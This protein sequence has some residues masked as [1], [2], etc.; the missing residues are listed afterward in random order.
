M[1]V[2]QNRVQRWNL[3]LTALNLQVLLALQEAIIQLLFGDRLQSV[4]V[5]S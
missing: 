4:I 5:G 3:V 1:Q 2:P